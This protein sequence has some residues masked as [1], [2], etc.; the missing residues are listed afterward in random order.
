[1][2]YGYLDESGDVGYVTGSSGH[3]VI[4]VVVVGR[5][6]RLR[7]AVTRTRKSL[8][9]RLR[10]IPELKATHDAP[11]PVEKLLAR[12]VET[13]F[14]AV[15]V[16]IDKRKI[17]PPEDPEE[18]YRISCARVVLEA[19]ERFGSLSLTLDRRYTASRQQHQLREALVASLGGMRGVALMVEYGD[20]KK[21]KALQVADA[22]A[23]AIFQRYEKGDETFWR[24]I[25]GYV[26]E[27][28]I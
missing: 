7:N 17:A 2:N 4:A 13:G 10:D 15:A 20:S 9:K 1:M 12:A 5:P 14:E 21:E 27:V 11:R 25:Q 26:K 22:V 16:V 6:D 24:I 28:R 18:L 19:L 8:G 3:L 23:W